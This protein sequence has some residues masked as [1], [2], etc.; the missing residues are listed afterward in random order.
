MG[1]AAL[2]PLSLG[3]AAAAKVWR[4]GIVDTHP[5]D[6]DGMGQRFVNAMRDLGY[7][8]GRD[9]EYV[10]RY[11]K[12]DWVTFGA[13][14]QV[15][16]NELVRS[17]LD[18]IVGSST[19]STKALQRATTT[20][21]IVTNAGDPVGAG[22]AKSVARP[23]GNITGVAL[24][25]P[26]LFRKVFEYLKAIIP[27]DWT[28]AT[29]HDPTR[30]TRSLSLALE[31]GARACAIPVRAVSFAGM[32][33]G[34]ADRALASMRG[35]GIRVLSA[36]VPIP[37]IPDEGYDLL[38]ATKYGLATGHNAGEDEVAKGALMSYS[39]GGDIEV[40]KAFQLARILRGT[41]PGEIPFE[42]PATYRL[43]INRKTAG[44]LGLTIPPGILLVAD[45]IYE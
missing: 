35:K 37:G 21:P 13:Q 22:F 23:G 24:A 42:T 29:A 17:R 25:S 14:L 1:A 36:L 33:A 15:I 6:K 39:P 26:E 7:V 12:G 43:V 32:D 44:I 27:G 38:M 11:P 4:V 3:L 18:A 41:P 45:K 19:P 40:R 10:H 9:I 34:Q 31:E 30:D 5:R 8:E 2:G 20:I 16:A 28:L